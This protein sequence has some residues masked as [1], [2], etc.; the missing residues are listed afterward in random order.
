MARELD[1]K[2]IDKQ[3]D[4]WVASVVLTLV[5]VIMLVAEVL[6]GKEHYKRLHAKQE[7][8][9]NTSE[10]MYNITSLEKTL[11]EDSRIFKKQLKKERI[12]LKYGPYR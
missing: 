11:E 6:V 1:A 5:V 2:F 10:Q 12:Q 4:G 3:V 8:K 7:Y 9:A